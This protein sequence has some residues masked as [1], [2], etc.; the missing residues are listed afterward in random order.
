MPN[1]LKGLAVALLAYGG[2]F[3]A[4]ILSPVVILLGL[5]SGLCLLGAAFMFFFWLLITHDP[6][7]IHGAL[8]LLAWGSPP[9]LAAGVLGYC[10]G[11]PRARRIQCGRMPHFNKLRQQPLAIM[12]RRSP[13][14]GPGVAG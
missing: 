8:Y 10:R 14:D 3:L 2:I 5:W 13:Q 7:T 9:C 6:N 11:Q 1:V 4:V 12:Q